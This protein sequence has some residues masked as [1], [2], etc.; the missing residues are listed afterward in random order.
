MAMFEREDRTD[1]QK[2]DQLFY[3]IKLQ[4][5]LATKMLLSVLEVI[6]QRPFD[7]GVLH[8]TSYPRSPTGSSGSRFIP[9]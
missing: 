4:R 5:G 6:G 9:K 1:R 2:S 8:N 3:K 7:K